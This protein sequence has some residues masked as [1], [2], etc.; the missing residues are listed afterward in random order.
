MKPF[1]LGG[2]LVVAAS[3]A[4]VAPADA[5]DFKDQTT[6]GTS[7]MY[8]TGFLSRFEL[9][10]GTGSF[11]PDGRGGFWDNNFQTFNA[12]RS[13]LSGSDFHLD[14]IYHFDAHN[15]LLVSLGYYEKAFD[16]P[17]RHQLDD[18]GN[19]IYHSLQIALVSTDVGYLLYPFGTEHRVAPYLGAGLNLSVGSLQAF[20]NEPSSPDDGSGDGGDPGTTDPGDPGDPGDPTSGCDT[21]LPASTSTII[22]GG[23][24]DIIALGYFFDAGLEVRVSPRVALFAEVRRTQVHANLGSDFKGMDPLDLSNQQVQAGLTLRF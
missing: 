17:A 10:G 22:P 23:Y 15:G 2:V 21:A 20:G 18:S 3:L 19:P 16:E 5:Q 1:T 14:G 12:K 6:T 4:F 9:R 11:T 13:Q 24:S 8:G 7:G